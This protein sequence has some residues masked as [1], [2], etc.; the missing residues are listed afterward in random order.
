MGDVDNMPKFLKG[1]KLSKM[2]QKEK[3]NTN[4]DITCK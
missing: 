2:I 3:E 1:Y 4:R